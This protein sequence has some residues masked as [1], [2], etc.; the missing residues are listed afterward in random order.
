VIVLDFSGKRIIFL[1]K[2]GTY[3]SYFNALLLNF[4]HKRQDFFA[5]FLK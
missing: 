4:Y 1:L 3:R 2:I 5:A